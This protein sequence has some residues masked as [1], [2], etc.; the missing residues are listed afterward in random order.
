MIVAKT[1]K[2]VEHLLNEAQAIEILGLGDRPNPG[3]SLRWL[4]R[5]HQ[6]VARS[7]A[8]G[9]LL[10]RAA[11]LNAYIEAMDRKGGPR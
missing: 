10:F 5:K 1:T 11:D 9:I 6:L 2:G 3:V 4:V 8:R 7:P